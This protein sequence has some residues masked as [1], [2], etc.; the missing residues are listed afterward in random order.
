MIADIV[1]PITYLPYLAKVPKYLMFATG[2]EFF[3]P[4][5]ARTFYDE[6]VAKGGETHL[7][8]VPFS[9]LPLPFLPRSRWRTLTIPSSP[10][11]SRR[12]TT[13]PPSARW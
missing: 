5:S 7:R 12:S 13:L 11:T 10:S 6:M 9:L 3:L 1:D 2:D 8:M 4:D